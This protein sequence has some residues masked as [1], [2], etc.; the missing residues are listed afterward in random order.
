MTVIVVADPDRQM[1]RRTAAALRYAGHTVAS[2]TIDHLRSLLH[3][4]R[5]VAVILTYPARIVAQVARH[6]LSTLAA[7]N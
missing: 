3:R 1:R 6:V 2:T 7:P 4:E 5:P